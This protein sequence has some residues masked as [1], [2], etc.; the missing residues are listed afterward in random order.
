MLDTLRRAA[1]G[2]KRALRS[3]ANGHAA[4]GRRP[5][6]V[7]VGAGFAGLS[8]AKTLA[9]QPVDVTV[10]DR[11]NYHKFQPLLYQV[12]TAGLEP[13]DVAH[14]VRDIFAPYANVAVR[15]GTV[16]EIDKEAQAVRTRSGTALPYDFLILA[17]GATSSYF[18][19]EGAREHSFPLKNLP[20][21]VALRNQVLRQFERCDR[22]PT[23]AGEGAL[24]FV[25][26]GGGPTGVEMAGALVELFASMRRDFHRF[27]TKAAARVV[28]VERGPQLLPS[29]SEAQ[30][31]YTRR[32]LEGRGVEV[33][34]GATV[35]RVA[36]SAVHFEEG[37]A[38]PA[39]TLVWAAGVQAN[40]VAGLVGTE[41]TGAGR[42]VVERDLSVPGHASI[43]AVGDL[44]AGESGEGEMYAQLA[45]VAIQQGRHA[46]RQ[47]IR[48]T[49]GQATRP[50]AYQNLG[51]MAT[52]G[53]NAAVAELPGGVRLYGF[54]AWAAWLFIHI[55]KLVGFRNRVN[56]FVS[57][58]YNYFTYQKSARLILDMVPLSEDVPM[59]IE[60]VDAE[61]KKKLAALAESA[62]EEGAAEEGRA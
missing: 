22:D 7:I 36:P 24:T 19:V 20:D 37:E 51:K 56:V 1:R 57:W 35:E 52:I 25:V 30:G 45:P 10:I 28:L 59:E 3:R 48:R 62:M 39:Q 46:A 55:A 5:R 34:L 49:R 15:L 16:S 58:A 33:R 17:A 60:N 50:F 53:R 13:E 11:N 38:L 54:V 61:V 47:V 31:A 44:G 2:A 21:A 27:D 14:N 26:V 6:V 8:A 9:G 43:F 4:S 18:G 29:Y 41:Q 23:G 40:A 42:L 32:V 12:G